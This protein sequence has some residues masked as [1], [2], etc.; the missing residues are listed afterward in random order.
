VSDVSLTTIMLFHFEAAMQMMDEILTHELVNPDEL[1][2]IL[3]YKEKDSES[4]QEERLW[5]MLQSFL[6]RANRLPA[7]VIPFSPDLRGPDARKE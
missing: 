5:K 1:Y 4:I 7:D 2:E 6:I 3:E